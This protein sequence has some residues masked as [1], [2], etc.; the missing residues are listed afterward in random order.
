MQEPAQGASDS[1]APDCTSVDFSTLYATSLVREE[2]V[3]PPI[4]SN[5][6]QSLRGQASLQQSLQPR[7]TRTTKPMAEPSIDLPQHVGHEIRV[8]CRDA[9]ACKLVLAWLLH[10]T[11]A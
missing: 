11:L 9:F 1:K 4:F 8:G 6:K 2:A 7:I 3:H 10:A 5:L